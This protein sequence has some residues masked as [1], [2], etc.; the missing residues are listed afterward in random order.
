MIFAFR[1][2]ALSLLLLLF[3]AAAARHQAIAATGS[4]DRMEACR[5]SS[6]PGSRSPTATLRCSTR[7]ISWSNPASASD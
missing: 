2:L 3:I 7:P 5:S 1:V 4:P 6:F